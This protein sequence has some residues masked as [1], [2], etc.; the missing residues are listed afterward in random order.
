MLPNC[1]TLGGFVNIIEMMFFK[2]GGARDSEDDISAEEEIQI[3][4]SRIQSQN[5]YGWRKKSISSQKIKGKKE[6]IR[7]GRI[8]VAYFPMFLIICRGTA[9]VVPENT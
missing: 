1:L 3:K 6:I 7:L 8:Y 9:A 4:S 5:E 2:M